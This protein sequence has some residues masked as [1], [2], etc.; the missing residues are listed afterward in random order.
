M[1]ASVDAISLFVADTA[2]GSM[3]TVGVADVDATCAE[4]SAA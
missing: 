3:F 4:L 2:A 1:R